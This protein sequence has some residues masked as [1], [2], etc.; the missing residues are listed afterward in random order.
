MR[1]NEAAAW[2]VAGKVRRL[3]R[4]AMRLVVRFLL[5]EF[6]LAWAMMLAGSIHVGMQAWPF[7]ANTLRAC[8]RAWRVCLG[9]GIGFPVM[10]GW[11]LLFWL[12]QGQPGYRAWM[13]GIAIPWWIVLGVTG[14]MVLIARISATG[15][16]AEPGGTGCR[17][18][19]CA[20]REG[21]VL[22]S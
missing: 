7:F 16:P 13:Q 21:H 5:L 4:S 6:S 17:C 10:A 8:L 11:P 2:P 18:G 9:V 19:S 12:R 1:T 3:R 22:P 20:A 15:Q 14:L